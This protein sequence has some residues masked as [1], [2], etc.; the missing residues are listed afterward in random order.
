MSGLLLNRIVE[1]KLTLSV[2]VSQELRNGL[3][4]WF[5]LRVSCDVLVAMSAR[6][7]V[8]GRLD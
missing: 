5:W 7:A 3:A 4:G 1:C 2:S 6:A 8:K